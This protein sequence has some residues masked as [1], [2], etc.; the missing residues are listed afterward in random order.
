MEE[1]EAI[2]GRR[3][4]VRRPLTVVLFDLFYPIFVTLVMV[5]VL[6]WFFDVP[7]DRILEDSTAQLARKFLF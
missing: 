7:I 2:R 5:I 4:R 1:Y 3:R 6:S